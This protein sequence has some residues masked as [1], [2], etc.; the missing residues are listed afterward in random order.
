MLWYMC[1]NRPR[2]HHPTNSLQLERHHQCMDLLFWCGQS[3]PSPLLS[4]KHLRIGQR[5]CKIGRWFKI[6][7]PPAD[8]G[9]SLQ[10]SIVVCWGSDPSGTS[11]Y[12]IL[13]FSTC[14][15]RTCLRGSADPWLCVCVRA[16]LSHHS[17]LA[18][19]RPRSLWVILPDFIQARPALIPRSY[20][21]SFIP[22]CREFLYDTNLQ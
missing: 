1:K 3:P 19:P 5:V 13:G 20:P 22:W 18:P 16:V 10:E 6:H 12:W 15:G 7:L 14:Y 2:Q 9:L 17:A 21:P 11:H 8:V 4:K